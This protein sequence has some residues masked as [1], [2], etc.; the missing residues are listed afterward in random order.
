MFH[1]LDATLLRFFK[2]PAAPDDLK[3][4]N[5]S[6]QTPDKDFAAGSPTLNLF[7][8]HVGENRDL[9]ANAPTLAYSPDTRGYPSGSSLC[10][11]T[12]RTW[13]PRGRTRR[14]RQG[15]RRARA[16]WLGAWLDQSQSGASKGCPDRVTRT[17]AGFPDH[18]VHR[19]THPRGD[20]EPLLECVGCCTTAGFHT[21]RHRGDDVGHRSEPVPPV[22]T[23]QIDSAGTVPTERASN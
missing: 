12:A 22:R 15:R 17:A 14:G 19:P 7:L 8:H 13:Q 1:D 6:F 10:A 2:L 18:D 5:V 4:A 20:A 23:I 16:P 3:A 21:R 9:R 11:L